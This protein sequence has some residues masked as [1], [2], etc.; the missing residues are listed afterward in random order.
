M[1]KKYQLFEV[2]PF[3]KWQSITSDDTAVRRSRRE[4][5]LLFLSTE[6]FNLKT[7][8]ALPLISD[9][10]GKGRLVEGVLFEN[11]DPFFFGVCRCTTHTHAYIKKEKGKKGVSHQLTDKYL[12]SEIFFFS[13]ALSSSSSSCLLLYALFII[14]IIHTHIRSSKVR[15]NVIVQQTMNI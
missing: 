6:T 13:R 15:K 7:H 1:E 9:I 2:S 10:E 5:G 3:F 4:N 11:F 14:T 12:N 8:D